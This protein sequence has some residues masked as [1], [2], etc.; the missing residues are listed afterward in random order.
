ML[1]LTVLAVA[2]F[3]FVVVAGR[4]WIDAAPSDD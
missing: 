2:G 1:T 4:E 3:V